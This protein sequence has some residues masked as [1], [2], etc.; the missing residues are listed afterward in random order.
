MK[1]KN[2]ACTNK[3]H[4]G[5]FVGEWCAPC[6]K[7]LYNVNCTRCQKH[8]ALNEFRMPFQATNDFVCDLCWQELKK[9][10]QTWKG[11]HPIA[12]HVAGL[13]RE[14]HDLTAAA[15][16]QRDQYKDMYEQL[17][18]EQYGETLDDVD[19]YRYKNLYNGLLA[20]SNE[21]TDRL[22]KELQAAKDQINSLEMELRDAY[23]GKNELTKILETKCKKRKETILKL[24]LHVI[25]LQQM[26]DR[27]DVVDVQRRDAMQARCQEKLTAM[28][29]DRDIIKKAYDEMLHA[30]VNLAEIIK[31][32][33]KKLDD[34][35]NEVVRLR[36]ELLSANEELM[37]FRETNRQLEKQL[38]DTAKDNHRLYEEVNSLTDRTVQEALNESQAHVVRLT[39]Q[40]D[41]D[42]FLYDELQ[43]ENKKL[44]DAL[45][46]S[47]EIGG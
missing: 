11:G 37:T 15:A 17:Y 7:R 29:Q 36:R 25:Q 2:P 30:N 34:M 40:R 26:L 23:V 13:L 35:T 18:K 33:E 45:H 27:R 10:Y 43:R 22:Q 4:E 32:R 5:V 39:K 9:Y 42:R 1:C 24:K 19:R 14:A 6:H 16:K 3:R 46:R 20:R 28:T 38:A 12:D 21:T 41:N 31:D 8:E 44:S 47:R